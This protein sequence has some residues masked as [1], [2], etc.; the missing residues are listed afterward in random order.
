MVRHRHKFIYVLFSI[1][2]FLVSCNRNSGLNPSNGTGTDT[3]TSEDTLSNYD[4]SK[5]PEVAA[6]EAVTYGGSTSGGA[7]GL[8]KPGNLPLGSGGSAS[9]TSPSSS[10]AECLR[11]GFNTIP[12]GGPSSANFI[13]DDDDAPSNLS[14]TIRGALPS[15][16]P[17]LSAS[18][19]S[20]GQ[21]IT[22]EAIYQMTG[23]M[24][25]TQSQCLEMVLSNPPRDGEDPNLAYQ[26]GIYALAQCY[27]MMAEGQSQQVPW[28]QT[29]QARYEENNSNL[30]PLLLM[31]MQSGN[32][33]E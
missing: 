6:S 32:E 5:D 30:L 29:Q 24:Y 4:S 28:A 12:S 16:S 27:G 18:T 13:N 2:F 31:M 11:T 19:N 25:Q 21:P 3:S 9:G 33:S 8:P 10:E 7:S 14:R 26:S 22:Q 15:A 20:K 23:N 17:C 1:F